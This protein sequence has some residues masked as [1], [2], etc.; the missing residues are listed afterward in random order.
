MSDSLV[1]Y[2]AI[3]KLYDYQLSRVSDDYAVSNRNE[4]INMK[5]GN[6]LKSTRDYGSYNKKINLK[7]KSGNPKNITCQ[8]HIIF[9]MAS[10]YFRNNP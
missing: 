6:K 2:V 1:K 10:R 3:N 5:T 4:I 9:E 8:E 7:S